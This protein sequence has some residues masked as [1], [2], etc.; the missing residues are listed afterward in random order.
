MNQSQLQ[1]IQ[2]VLPHMKSAGTG[3]IVAVSSTAGLVG[4]AQLADYCA[5]KFGIIGLMESLDAELDNDV[6]HRRQMEWVGE[7]IERAV[8]IHLTTVCPYF[9]RSGMFNGVNTE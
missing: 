3:H 1:T 5:S 2:A 6:R 7:S 8:D 4:T 9:V